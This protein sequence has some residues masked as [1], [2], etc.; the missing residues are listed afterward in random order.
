MKKTKFERLD[1]VPIHRLHYQAGIN[2]KG[3][4]IVQLMHNEEI[5]G[6]V[7]PSE[8]RTYAMGV[9]EAAQ[10]CETYAFVIKLA[11]EKLH[12]SFEEAK[13][14]LIKAGAHVSS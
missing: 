4:P 7:T 3:E 1:P 11:Q 2:P 10:I 6:L 12:M 14:T 5:I 8:A 9:F 13:E